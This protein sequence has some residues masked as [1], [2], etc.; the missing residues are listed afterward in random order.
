MRMSLTETEGHEMSKFLT[1]AARAPYVRALARVQA[2][3]TSTE[4]ALE[5]SRSDVGGQA[6]VTLN[7]VLRDYANGRCVV[8]RQRTTLDTVPRCLTSATVAVL[9]PCAMIDA[10]QE[11]RGYVASNVCS[12]CRACV[13]ASNANESATGEAHVWTADTLDAEFVPLT[14][15]SLPKTKATLTPAEI[16]HAEE[17]RR[18]WVARGM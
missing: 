6:M 1:T 4:G 3:L 7:R 10:S 17:S 11:R 16:A 18:V 13:N 5:R 12:I 2:S 8:C 9:I 14:W 15:P